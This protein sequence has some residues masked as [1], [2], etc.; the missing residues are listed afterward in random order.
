MRTARSSIAAR[1]P[2]PTKRRGPRR[3]HEPRRLPCC[4]SSNSSWPC[5][6]RSTGISSKFSSETIVTSAAPPRMAARAESSASFSARVGLA[7]R[8]PSSSSSRPSRERRARGVERD[9]AAADHD[10]AAAEI[11]AVAAVDVEQVVDG[12]DDAVEL[13]AGDLRDRGRATRRPTGRPPR[14][15]ARAAAARPKPAAS[16]VFEL[17]ASTPSARIL[18]ISARSS[19][20]GRRYSGM[21]NRIMPPGSAAA[22]KTVTS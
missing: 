6:V 19:V 15:P 17:R 21:P 1:R 8:A 22:S 2:S 16:G 3:V 10:D 11:H 14:S 12:L 5:V 4:A 13:D 18:S 7:V 9:E 20:R